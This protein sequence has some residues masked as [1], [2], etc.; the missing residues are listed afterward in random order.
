MFESS[1]VAKIF[2]SLIN[3]IIYEQRKFQINQVKLKN[4]VP[5][6]NKTAL[7]EKL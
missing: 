5:N 3:H 4:A 7:I 2:I 6:P 1:L